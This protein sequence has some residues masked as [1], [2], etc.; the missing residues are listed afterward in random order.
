MTR[1]ELRR[2]ALHAWRGGSDAK[3]VLH[4]ALLEHYGARYQRL[5][6]LAEVESSPQTHFIVIVFDPA[7]LS[8]K[9]GIPP[10]HLYEVTANGVFVYRSGIR[11]WVLTSLL[12]PIRSAD[13]LVRQLRNDGYTPAEIAQRVRA[14]GSTPK[15]RL[16]WVPTY[17]VSG[18]RSH[19]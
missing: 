10:F 19:T 14:G 17:M 7:A 8:K 3:A 13:D 6:D 4:D 11:T 1:R 2:M 9:L 12:P 18:R 5:I 15:R 16:A